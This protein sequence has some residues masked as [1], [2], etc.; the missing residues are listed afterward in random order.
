MSFKKRL[1]QTYWERYQTYGATPRGSF[2]LTKARQDQR[3]KLILTAM[4]KTQPPRDI[5]LADVGCGYGALAHYLAADRQ[6]DDVTYTG[7]DISLDLVNECQS[8]F[9]DPRFR[10]VLGTRPEATTACVV[11][12]G[13]YNLAAT[14]ELAIWEDYVTECL[15]NCWRK[16]SHAMIFNLQIAPKAYIA[17]DSIYYA[18]CD[19]ILELCHKL[20]GPTKITV[21]RNLSNDATFCVTK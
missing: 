21:A 17:H 4:A 11:M 9:D 20:F 18:R 1:S 19:N 5:T 12:S 7:Y 2:W 14:P 13:T 16:T 8:M 6:F 10:F 3:F 15:Q